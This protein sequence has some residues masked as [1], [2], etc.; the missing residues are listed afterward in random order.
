LAF[1]R[2]FNRETILDEDDKKEE[3]K[4]E[5]FKPYLKNTIV[6]GQRGIIG[7]PSNF[8]DVYGKKLFVG[9]TV[10]IIDKS[11]FNDDDREE[12][13]ITYEDT[14]FNVMGL[15]G[16]DFSK[17]IQGDYA[18]IKMRSFEDVRDGEIIRYT[19]YVKTKR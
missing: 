11:F 4:D 3:V 1:T 6:G 18:I 2:L 16:K 15:Y 7:T 13:F 10:K 12:S 14:R 8:F 5:E 19:E 9:D 17:G